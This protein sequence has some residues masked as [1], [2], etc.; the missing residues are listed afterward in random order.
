MAPVLAAGV[1]VRHGWTWVLRAASFRLDSPAAGRPAVGI[2][3]K[4][5]TAR[6]AV[7]DL[8]GGLA[9]PAYGELRVLG[10]DL[11][12]PQGRAAVRRYV[13]IARVS[14]RP[15]PVRRVR[16]VV[17]HATQLASLPGRDRDA[18]AAAILDRLA[19]TPWADVPVRA[20][21][22]VIGR[23]ARLA[24]A[25]VHEPELLLIDGLLDGLGPR[26][27]AGVADSIRDLSRDTAI[28]A[29]GGDAAALSLACDEVLTLADGII[30]RD[31]TRAAWPGRPGQAA[32]QRGCRSSSH[33]LR[34]VNWNLLT[35]AVRPHV[36]YA[37]TEPAVRAGLRARTPAGEAWRC[38]RCGTFVPGPP[39]ASGPAAAAPRVRRDD[40]LRSALILRAFAVERFLRAIV[41][42]VIAYG[43]WR[44]KYSRTSIEHT[45]DRDYPAIKS[46][47]HGLGYNITDGSGLVG[48]IRHTFTLDQRTLTWL[49]VGA[50]AYTVVE[51][52]EG[53]A[54][55]GLR[56]WGEY[57][58]M[59]VTSLGI[60]YEIYELVAK[61]TALRLTAFIINV[62]LV[63]YLVLA[64]RLF[65]VRGGKAAYEDR[66]RSESI[67]QAAID[68]A[69]APGVPA[70]AEAGCG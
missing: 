2:A 28:I 14:A 41:F 12:T 46:L 3:V 20:T 17:G 56:R 44:F 16:S 18:L 33:R 9:R 59:I 47:A 1:G 55:W 50:A 5:D 35:C 22:A 53:I 68:A 67:M 25:A 26:D 19:L 11:T 42:G 64:K 45:F 51:I 4:R 32:T 6:S 49:A 69:A 39:A 40:E 62:A 57:F 7:A 37:P 60:P 27:V 58:A 48:L 61:V 63:V 66:L 13:G 21:P 23:R 54:L 31:L 34:Q 70:S 29:I 38:L 52:L 43:V 8:L 15:R 36:S 30:V 24:A 65:G 10:Q